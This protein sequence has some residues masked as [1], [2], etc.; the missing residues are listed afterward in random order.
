MK[1]LRSTPI[2]GIRDSYT[3][4][5]F[6]L[7]FHVRHY[8]LALQ[9]RVSSNFLQ[10]TAVLSMDNYL[11]LRELTLDLVPQLRVSRVMAQGI[12]GLGIEVKKF[13][14][15][16][17]KLRIVFAATIPVD[18]QFVLSIAYSGK[19]TAVR[20]VWGTLGWEEL[21]NGSL[22]A[23]QPNGAPS[24]FPCDDT[25]DE[26]A[27]YDITV[28]CDNPYTVVTNGALLGKRR[29]GSRTT[30][31]YRSGH[32]M[33]S[34][35]ATVMVGEFEQLTLA[36]RPV[37]VVAYLP[38]GAR[39]DFTRAFADQ[40]R[41][42]ELFCKLFGPYPFQRYVVV[43]T[44]DDLE[45]P[46]EAQELSIFGR[47]HVNGKWERLIAHE[48][49][50]QWFGNSLG[51]AQWNDI[52]LNEGFACYAEWLWFEHTTGDFPA[53]H[54][55]NILRRLPQ[56]LLLADPG[57]RLMFDD[58][59]YKRGALTVHAIRCLLGDAAFF[60]MV[61]RYI[62]A[63]QHGVVEPMDL[64]LACE[65][66]CREENIPIARFHALW[67]AWLYECALPPFPEARA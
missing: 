51:L 21:E 67:K 39:H 42:L 45:I 30:W 8:N 64:R 47:N 54:H 16:H 43:I 31:H 46:L 29:H 14:Q 26:K 32:A 59:V 66:A 37:P 40:L 23:S 41:M 50:H 22:V 65:L 52:W 19:P 27:F 63:G 33:A 58:R 12:G 38:R 20:T 35:L 61:R 15:A 48:L 57:P 7:G 18:Q 1:R 53:R 10:G 55:Y 62:A 36:A 49:S 4:V 9:Y 17:G 13:S 25:P 6:N 44:E 56:D 5:Y 3:G 24:W 11:P 60:R 28:T 2:P 34:Y